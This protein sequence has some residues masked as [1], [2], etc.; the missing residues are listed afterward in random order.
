[1]PLQQSDP[2]THQPFVMFGGTPFAIMIIPVK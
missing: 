1:L 2:D